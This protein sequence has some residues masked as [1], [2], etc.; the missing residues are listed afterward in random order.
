MVYFTTRHIGLFLV[1]F[2]TII[3]IM[4]ALVDSDISFVHV[5]PV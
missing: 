2:I 4:D 5:L 1:F 3:L